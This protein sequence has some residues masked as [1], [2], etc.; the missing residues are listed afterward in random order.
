LL[1]LSFYFKLISLLLIL[2]L[3]LEKGFKGILDLVVL[4]HSMKVAAVAFVAAVV[5]GQMMVPIRN[6]GNSFGFDY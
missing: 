4:D 1:L 3:L 5:V 6:F 2:L